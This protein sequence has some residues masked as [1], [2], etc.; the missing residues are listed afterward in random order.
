MAQLLHRETNSFEAT[1][2]GLEDLSSSPYQGKMMNIPA[3][4]RLK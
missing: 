4:C 2:G 1:R 3:E